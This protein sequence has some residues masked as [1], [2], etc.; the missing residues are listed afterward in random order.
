MT[1]LLLMRAARPLDA[2]A[3]ALTQQWSTYGLDGSNSALNR[4]VRMDANNLIVAGNTAI[5]RVLAKVV[6]DKYPDLIAPTLPQ[7]SERSPG[8]ASIAWDEVTGGGEMQPYHGGALTRV[9]EVAN[10]RTIQSVAHAGAFGWTQTELLRAALQDMSLSTRKASLARRS[11]LERLETV[12]LLGDKGS[13]LTGFL[14][15]PNIP[16]AVIVRD[17]R[18]GNN[19]EVTDPTT[20]ALDGSDGSTATQIR[21]AL[22]RFV[23]GVAIDTSEAIQPKGSLMIPPKAWRHCNETPMDATNRI[24]IREEFERLS[25]IKL[26]K[27]VRLTSVPTSVSGLSAVKNFVVLCSMDGMDGEVVIPNP[28]QF[29]AVQQVGLEYLVPHYAEIAGWASFVP[30]A[31]RVGYY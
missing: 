10:R 29:F 19:G 6:E 18:L 12:V 15:D 23:D 1:S 11:Y 26:E 9:D 22:L 5:E 17:P 27:S 3:P 28:Q 20:V 13:Q 21:D 25:G 24:S 16:R 8:V 4:A 31:H 7:S 14:S 30:K 2:I